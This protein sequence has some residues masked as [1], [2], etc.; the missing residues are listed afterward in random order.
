MYYQDT[1]WTSIT[2][3]SSRGGLSCTFTLKAGESGHMMVTDVPASSAMLSSMSCT[4]IKGS[5]PLLGKASYSVAV[6]DTRVTL[7]ESS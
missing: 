4:S 6:E 1:I 3:A 7:A 2:E 5:N